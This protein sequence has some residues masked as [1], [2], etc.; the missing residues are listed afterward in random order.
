MNLLKENFQTPFKY[1]ESLYSFKCKINKINHFN[2]NQMKT[3]YKLKFIE[4][5]DSHSEIEI[6]GC[7]NG[8]AMA[9]ET[10]MIS[11]AI[12]FTI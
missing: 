10:T 7:E 1:F 2:L 5:N 3:F 12:L 4:E 11:K 8:G 9:M 6:S